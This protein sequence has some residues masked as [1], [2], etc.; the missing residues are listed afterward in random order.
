MTVNPPLVRTQNPNVPPALS[1][2]IKR[3]MKKDR[4]KRPQSAAEVTATVRQIAKELQAKKTGPPTEPPKLPLVSPEPK[5]W[6]LGLAKPIT[7]SLGMSFARIPA[8]KCVRGSPETDKHGSE[9]ERPQRVIEISK[10][11]YLGIYEVTQAEY[12][13]VMDGAT[14]SN[15]KGDFLLVETVSL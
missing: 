12:R 3:L 9:D 10:E 2:L 14:P 13:R 4:A 15:F 11:F 7:N 1:D 5:N 6:P 8:G